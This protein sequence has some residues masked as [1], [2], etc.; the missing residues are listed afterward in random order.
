MVEEEQECKN[1]VGKHK[2]EEQIGGGT[3][4]ETN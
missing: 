1:K 3:H 4:G 2:K